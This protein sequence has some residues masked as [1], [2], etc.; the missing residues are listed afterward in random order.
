MADQPDAG[1]G[2][3]GRGGQELKLLQDAMMESPAEMPGFL[4]F[5][6]G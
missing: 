1:Q 6:A 2:Q 3:G 4:F 5:A